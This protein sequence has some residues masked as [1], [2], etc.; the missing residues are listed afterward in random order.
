MMACSTEVGSNI[1]CS[2]ILLQTINVDV[3][4]AKAA[5]LYHVEA[6]DLYHAQVLDPYNVKAIDLYRVIVRFKGVVR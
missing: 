5:N 6:S 1:S 3:Y 2:L 4:Y